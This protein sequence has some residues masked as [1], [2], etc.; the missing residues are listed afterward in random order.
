MIQRNSF[1]IFDVSQASEI[2]KRGAERAIEESR[3]MGVPIPL[4]TE[5]GSIQYELPDGS[6]VQGD[7]WHGKRTAPEGWYERFQIPVENR[8]K[9][10]ETT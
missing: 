8:P 9:V 10:K 3:K 7:P 2:M 6:I 4:D 1:E 5:D